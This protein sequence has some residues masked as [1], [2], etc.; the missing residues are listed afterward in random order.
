MCVYIY[1]YI[2]IHT[3]VYAYTIQYHYYP[4][5]RKR[6]TFLLLYNGI[7]IMVVAHSCYLSVAAGIRSYLCL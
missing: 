3:C 2:H 4:Y 6:F 5:Y 1:I 7:V